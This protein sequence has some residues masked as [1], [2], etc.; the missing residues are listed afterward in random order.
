M[1]EQRWTYEKLDEDGNVKHC[2]TNDAKGE[3]TGK[4]I[5]G[6]K[7][8][9]DENPEERKRLGWIKHITHD[10]YK[11]LENF[12]KQSQYLSK[13]T[14][15]VD[16][17]TV[18]DVYNILD[19]SEEQLLLEEIMEGTDVYGGGSIIFVGMEEP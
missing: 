1:A 4:Y 7:E 16:E 18:E 2:P 15:Q 10:P 5:I 17:F 8:Y 13:T 12:N 6:L 14:V 19:K 11:E 9:F 3:I